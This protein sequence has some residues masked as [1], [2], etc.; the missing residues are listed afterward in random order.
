M[1]LFSHSPIR[2]PQLLE[3]LSLSTKCTPTVIKGM[4]LDSR[5]LIPGDLFVALKGSELDGAKFVPEAIKRGAVAVLLETGKQNLA[6]A[7]DN[8]KTTIPIIGVEDLSQNVSTI[9]SRFYGGPSER[10]DITGVTGTNGK[11]TCC[12]LYADLL[13]QLKTNCSG[14]VTSNSCGYIGTLGHGFSNHRESI[15]DD[16]PENTGVTGGAPLTT[17]DAITMQKLLHEF[18]KS[19]CRDVAIEVSSHSLVQNRISA[20]KIDTAI[21]TN[22]SRDHL[23]YHGDLNSYAA[24]KASLFKMPGLKNAVINIDDNIGKTIFADLDPSI[25]S[26]S[27]S[28][29]NITADIYCQSIHLRPDGMDAVIQTPWGSGKLSSPLLGK[30]NLSNLLAVIGAVAL[31]EGDLGDQHFQQILTLVPKLKAVVGRMEL[32]SDSADFSVIVDYAHT[33]DA[34]EQALQALR[35]HCEGNLWVVFGC[36]GD[37]DTGKRPEMGAIAFKYAD[38]VVITSD[39]PRTESPNQIISQI[40]QGVKGQCIIESDRRAAIT[41]AILEAKPGDVVLIAGKGHENYQIL[42]GDRIAFS[43]QTEARS[44][45]HQ[46]SALQK[47]GGAP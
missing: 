1:S 39:N 22:L 11:T 40:V 23:D 3:G 27:F 2:L 7:I 18:E 26:L 35:L 25:R 12:Q 8:I 20:V 28:L 29:E 38:R 37:R 36:G 45:L 17:P 10:L 14:S 19:G 31:H 44:A 41:K 9:A 32:V 24:A 33:P 5:A 47:L 34:L 6:G 46:R 21:F 42:G 30:F 13:S 43:D 15:C 4:T 16:E